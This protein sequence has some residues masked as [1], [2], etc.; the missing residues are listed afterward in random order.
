MNGLLEVII[1]MEFIFIGL[2]KNPYTCYLS[3]DRGITEI[4]AHL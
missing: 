3:Q 4:S 1:Y 2:E